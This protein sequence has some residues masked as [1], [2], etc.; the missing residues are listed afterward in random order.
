MTLIA[1]KKILIFLAHFA[2]LDFQLRNEGL[3]SLC[4]TC[5]VLQPLNGLWTAY[6]SKNGITKAVKLPLE[7][8]THRHHRP[9]IKNNFN[10]I[11]NYFIIILRNLINWKNS[12]LPV[13]FRSRWLIVSV[14]EESWSVKSEAEHFYSVVV[15]SSFCSRH[16]VQA[17]LHIFLRQHEYRWPHAFRRDCSSTRCTPSPTP[18][19]FVKR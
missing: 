2:L 8:T 15:L 12:F 1:P 14:T 5:C 18:L 7:H 4:A 11:T 17:F 16:F 6:K 10:F 19:K 9:Q 3:V 13:S